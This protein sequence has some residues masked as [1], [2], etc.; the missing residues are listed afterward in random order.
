VPASSEVQVV[1]PTGVAL[2]ARPAGLF[3]KTAMRFEA[4]LRIEAGGKQADAKSILAVLALGAK[5]GTPLTLS[6]DGPDA[7]VA[8]DALSA[9]VAGLVE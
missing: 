4:R 9:C 6:A 3:V 5:G 7:D 2:H 8:L 1:L